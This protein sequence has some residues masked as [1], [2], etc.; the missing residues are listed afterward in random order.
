MLRLS[1]V[2]CLVVLLVVAAGCK[3]PVLQTLDP[4]YQTTHD[5]PIGQDGKV[6]KGGAM[7]TMM[8][9]D[10]FEVIKLKNKVTGSFMTVSCTLSPQTFSTIRTDKGQYYVSS[11]RDKARDPMPNAPL[12]G[13]PC[14][15][16]VNPQNHMDTELTVDTSTPGCADCGPYGLNWD[17]GMMPEIEVEPMINIFAP[18]FLRKTLKFESYSGGLLSLYLLEEKGQPNGYTADGREELTKPI[19]N[20][21]VLT[22]ELAQ[23]K[24]IEVAGATIEIRKATPNELVYTVTKPMVE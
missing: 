21:Q 11:A 3:Q 18:N 19:M 5:G 4:V 20:E 12:D 6:G 13:W 9:G 16:R 23:S 2:I 22:F 15:L 10:H 1:S 17:D 8:Q 7:L 14:G 24:T